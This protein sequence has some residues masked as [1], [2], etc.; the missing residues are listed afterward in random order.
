[1]SEEIL[2][3]HNDLKVK[4]LSEQYMNLPS[5]PEPDDILYWCKSKKKYQRKG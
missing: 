3:D 2:I 4:H 5:A 1:M